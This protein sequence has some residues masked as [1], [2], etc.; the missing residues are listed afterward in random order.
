[1]TS[2]SSTRRCSRILRTRAWC[3]T[4]WIRRR[5][6]TNFAPPAS[7]PSGKKSSATRPGKFSRNPSASSHNTVTEP[8]SP[9]LAA[10]GEAEA[11][12]SAVGVFEVWLGWCVEA[13]AAALVAAEIF[14]LLGGV[15]ARY[16]FNRPLVWSDELASMLF[17]WLAM[18]GAAI[19]FHRDEHMRMTACAGILPGA[20]GPPFG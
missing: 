15:I 10:P 2:P 18:L 5:S 19:A 20:T 14:I 13:A 16:A 6:V 9:P 8:Q 1:M 12:R 11:D 4:S 7:I 3:S 17:L